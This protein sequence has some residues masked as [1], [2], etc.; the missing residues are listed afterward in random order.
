MKVF[1]NG[2]ET[3]SGGEVK[4][5]YETKDSYGDPIQLTV[6]ANKDGINHSVVDSTVGEPLVFKEHATPKEIAYHI[7]NP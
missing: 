2:L 6:T 7:L 4:I 5:V 3:L 1:I